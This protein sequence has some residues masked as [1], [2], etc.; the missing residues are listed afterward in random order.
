MRLQILTISSLAFFLVFCFFIDG[1]MLFGD[2]G[3]IN[4]PMNEADLNSYQ[5]SIYKL[6]TLTEYSE[7]LILKMLLI[8]FTFS[9]IMILFDRYV[10][11]ASIGMWIIYWIITNS[12]VRYAYGADYFMVFLLYYN[13]LLNI[14]RNKVDTHKYLVIM[15][16]LHLCLV[17]FFAGLG[18]I[19]GT[20]WW[21]GNAMWSV[22][23][24]YSLDIYKGYTEAFLKLGPV[25]QFLSIGTVMVELFYP[26]LIYYKR[27]RLITLFSVIAMHIGIAFVMG[28]F[29]F[30]LVMTMMNLIA[31]GHYL[32]IKNPLELLNSNE[33]RQTPS[34][35]YI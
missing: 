20:D 19:V 14:F 26:V 18:K 31:F 32:N 16:Q 12:G 2:G 27:T 11:L 3:I 35:S 8:V 17:Y 10:I 22:M 23:T 4:G 1:Q 21:D 34:P 9:F 30:G 25:L 13:V 5:I 24:V 28:L 7:H 6:S 15:L 33:S 29:T